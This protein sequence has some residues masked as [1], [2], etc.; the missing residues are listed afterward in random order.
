MDL[1]QWLSARANFSP[2]DATADTR[3]KVS[4]GRKRPEGGPGWRVLARSAR[5][6]LWLLSRSG[7]GPFPFRET[8]HARKK[9]ACITP[10]WLPDAESSGARVSGGG[11]ALK[12]PAS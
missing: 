1:L 8:S 6:S 2:S 5:V 11:G 10:V 3:N 12:S 4:A 7:T 9:K